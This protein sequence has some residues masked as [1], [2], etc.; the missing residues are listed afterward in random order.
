M[1]SEGGEGGE[2][3][4]RPCVLRTPLPAGHLDVCPYGAMR[5]QQRASTFPFQR[6]AVLGVRL[7]VGYQPLLWGPRGDVQWPVLP[8]PGSGVGFAVMVAAAAPG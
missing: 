4:W 2:A 1:A 6:G 5:R 3:V 8:L 7:C